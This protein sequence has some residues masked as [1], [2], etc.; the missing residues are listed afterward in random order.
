MNSIRKYRKAARL[1]QLQ[2][3]D[4]IGVSVDTIRRLEA[5]VR[6]PRWNTAMSISKVLSEKIGDEITP[7]E[8]MS[9][10]CQPPLGRVAGDSRKAG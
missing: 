4:E 8:L 1:T 2:L 9:N 7:E 3:A 6:A 5:D 10:P